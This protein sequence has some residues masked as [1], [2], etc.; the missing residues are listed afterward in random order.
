MLIA[1]GDLRVFFSNWLVGS[2]TGLA[3]F[4]L[5]WP[6]FTRYRD[7]VRKPAAAPAA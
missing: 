3:L 4:M 6:L 7:R 2:M 1:Q 5:A